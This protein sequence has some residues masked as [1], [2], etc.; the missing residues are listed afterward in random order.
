MRRS[1][2][3]NPWA[4][5]DGGDHTVAI[6]LD[7][8]VVKA[9]FEQGV[10]V[11]GNLPYNI[12]YETDVTKGEITFYYRDDSL[13]EKYEEASLEGKIKLI[14]DGTEY[15]MAYD[16]ELTAS[17]APEAMDYN[18]NAVLKLTLGN[19]ENEIEVVEAYA[20]L[21]ALGQSSKFTIDPALM[22]ATIAVNENVATGEK[23]IP[24]TVKDQYG[25]LYETTA[26]VTVVPRENNGDFAGLE[27]KLD[28]LQ[29]LGVNTVWI[30]PVVENIE[31]IFTC[32]G[33]TNQYNSGYHGYWASDFTKLNKHLGTGQMDSILDFDFNDQALSFVNGNL[34]GV[35]SFMEGR[36]AG[37]NNTATVGSFLSSH[38]E[39]GL[40]YRMM[41][42]NGKFSQD[43]AYDLMKVAAT[44]Q[45]TAKGQPV[46]YYGE[47]LGQ[48]GANNWPYQDNRYDMDWASANGD[49]DMLAHYIKL[50][51]IRNEYTDVFAKGGR[52]TVKLDQS[53]GV[54]VVNR[55][56]GGE[57]LYVGFNIN[58]TEVK[59]VTISLNAGT[60]YTDLYNGTTY[61]TDKN[62]EVTITIPAA[63]VKS[64][65]ASGADFRFH[66]GKDIVIVFTHDTLAEVAGDLDMNILVSDDKDFGQNFKSLVLD[67]RKKAIY[68]A[69]LAYAFNLGTENAGKTAFIFQRN[70][71]N[72]QVELLTTCIIGA[73]GNIA[74]P[75]VNYTDFI[76]LY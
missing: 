54:L 35:E 71:E 17:V 13:F 58:Q 51:N 75:G 33:Y 69:K 20:D 43:K 37:I 44:L 2:A 27:A 41:N 38:D 23:D 66:Y 67:P 55:S 76:I 50:L 11:T 10:G 64:M 29:D 68:G 42:E 9:E 32:D 18:D 63:E 7:Q 4:E 19:E 46:I 39:D 45:I 12:G 22:E 65:V 47:E 25:N 40:M 60:A 57:A 74:L 8:K 30:T 14:C 15:E 26:T 16:A 72:D 52:S 31:D 49:N 1:E 3:G 73:D 5:K 21:S 24:V 48:T 59:N 6:P 36:N 61:T 62:G 56:Y 28:Y 34:G 53:N 70:L